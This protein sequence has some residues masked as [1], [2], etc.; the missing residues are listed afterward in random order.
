MEDPPAYRLKT[1]ILTPG[2]LLKDGRYPIHSVLPGCP[3]GQNKHYVLSQF[4]YTDGPTKLSIY[5]LDCEFVLMDDDTKQVGHVSLVDFYGDVVLDE[6]VRPRGQIKKL[7][8]AK[9]NDQVTYSDMEDTINR[10]KEIH[11]GQTVVLPPNNGKITISDIENA[12]YS[13][14]EIQDKLLKI[15]TAEDVIIGH[16]VYE[17]FK[18]LEWKHTQILDTI[19]IFDNVVPDGSPSLKLLIG[20]FFGPEYIQEELSPY[21]GSVADAKAALDLAKIELYN[22]WA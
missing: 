9:R 19:K 16:G 2:D 6:L 4:P 15:V 1:L 13:F 11:K 10:L 17:D 22:S 20:H 3:E 18:A 7:L 21:S 5:A 12:K 8:F 14:K